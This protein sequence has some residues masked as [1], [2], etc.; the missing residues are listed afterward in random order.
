MRLSFCSLLFILICCGCQK[1]CEDFETN[2]TFYPS[3]CLLKSKPSAFPPLNPEECRTDWGK[4]LR[5]A[6]V[7]SKEQ[8][9][10]RAITSCKRGLV[11]LPPR[12]A[13]KKWQFEYL[14]VQSYYLGYKYQEAVEAFEA[15]TL[16]RVTKEFPAFHD[17]LIMMY[18]SY[19]RIGEEE[20]AQDTMNVIKANY[21]EDVQSLELSAALQEADFP[22]ISILAESRMDR[23]EINNFL[24][25]YCCEAKSVRRAETFQAL[26]PGAGYYYVGQTKTALTSLLI[27]SLFI[28]A[29]WNF[30][31]RG[32]TAAGLIT[33]SLELGWYLGGINGAGLAAKEYNERLYEGNA[34][35]FM[36]KRNFFPILM[37]QTNF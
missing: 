33:T 32:D 29:A 26:L 34:K 16:C 12:F 14:I 9:Y 35:E 2:I 10:Y 11:L 3:P 30:F 21:P 1:T 19:S 24:G 31:E 37:L 28:W 13:D 8:D 5:I 27:N 15:T 6:Y 18:E 7:F 22:A 23:D 17:L 25:N 20:K 4:E 36:R